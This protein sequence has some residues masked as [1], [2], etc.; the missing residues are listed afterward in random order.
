[1]HKQNF[2]PIFS[3]A[4]LGPRKFAYLVS[5]VLR[6]QRVSPD[7]I[8]LEVSVAYPVAAGK[9]FSSDG[10]EPLLSQLEVSGYTESRLAPTSSDNASVRHDTLG[11]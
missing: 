6:C 2:K 7:V 5:R 9:R 8:G 1:M 10:L 11:G 4:N 3:S